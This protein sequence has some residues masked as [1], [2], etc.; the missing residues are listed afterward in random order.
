MLIKFGLGFAAVGAYLIATR[1]INEVLNFR[2]KG[3]YWI[4]NL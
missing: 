1:R 2:I 3:K 4:L